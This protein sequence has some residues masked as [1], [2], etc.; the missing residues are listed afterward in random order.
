VTA[1]PVP[2]FAADASSIA[3][4]EA[5]SRGGGPRALL[6]QFEISKVRTFPVGRPADVGE[7]V[8][9][10]VTVTNSG[11]FDLL[12]VPMEDT[13][14]TNYLAIQGGVPAPDNLVNDG[15]LNWSSLGALMPGQ[16]ATATVTFTA[17]AP[18]WRPEETNIVVVS[19]TT[20][21]NDPVLPPQTAAAPYAVV[22]PA[23]TLGDT[24]WYDV[25]KDGLPDEDLSTCGLNHVTV[26][27]Y[28][29]RNGT[30]VLYA[31]TVTAQG[32]GG[33]RGYYLFT[34]LP[35]GTYCVEVVAGTVPEHLE[36]PT[37]PLTCDRR[38]GPPFTHRDAD[39]GFAPGD[40]TAIELLSFNAAAQGSLMA[41]TWATAWERNT[42]G[43]HLYRAPGRDAARQRLTTDPIPGQGAEYG[44]SYQYN[45]ASVAAGM[46]Y[47]YW[48]EEVEADGD[49]TLYGPV[50]AHTGGPEQGALGGFTASAD[51]AVLCLTFDN[52]LAAGI[53]A[54]AL[55]PKSV[56]LVVDGRE[57]PA[58]VMACGAS[59]R[60]GDLVL[61]YVRAADTLRHVDIVADPAPALRM[62]WT[63]VEPVDGEGE[64]LHAE[65]A[66]GR[67]VFTAGTGVVR[68]LVTGFRAEPVWLFDVTDADAPVFLFGAAGL[69]GAPGCGVYFSYRPGRPA[70]ILAVD[71]AAVE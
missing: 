68:C 46:T 65:A 53:V 15:V 37:T 50:A 59:L 62:D 12:T 16:V 71:N 64:V 33:A 5:A 56:H 25:D 54:E 69:D 63:Y 6:P 26:R 27:L 32:P 61:A 3:A 10:V 20:S 36:I 24:V 58:L 35:F 51:E 2:T 55:D 31:T 18:T 38:I 39:F 41:V 9:F 43:F 57:V 8:E 14:D 52:L 40:P 23:G 67:A 66:E 13:Y 60:Q 21:T 49:A 70:R 45:D 34:G 7:R 29:Q 4:A 42:L 44:F 22:S 19:P 30:P 47:W 1:Q 11:L 17:V 48:L 28:Q